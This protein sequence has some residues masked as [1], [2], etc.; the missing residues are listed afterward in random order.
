MREPACAPRLPGLCRSSAGVGVLDRSAKPELRPG[1]GSARTPLPGKTRLRSEQTAD[2]KTSKPERSSYKS[3][4]ES[5][6][7]SRAGQLTKNPSRC[8]HPRHRC[9]GRCRNHCRYRLIVVAAI[10]V[11]IA[12]LAL[13][14]ATIV[15]LVLRGRVVLAVVSPTRAGGDAQGEGR[16]Q[17]H[18]PQQRLVRNSLPIFLDHPDLPNGLILIQR[19]HSRGEI[20]PQP[21]PFHSLS[22]P[23]Q[24]LQPR[25]RWR[26]H[27][28]R[29]QAPR[30]PRD[31]GYPGLAQS[32]GDGADPEGGRAQ[33]DQGS[34]DQQEDRTAGVRQN[35]YT[36]ARSRDDLIVVRAVGVV[37]VPAC[38]G[39]SRR[40]SRAGD[41]A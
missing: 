23:L 37:I 11:V 14:T 13:T 12:I 18:Y 35:A 20:E 1:P 33:G 24:R 28:E 4:C 40:F 26:I 6:H 7:G 25:T 29:V 16:Y 19:T 38:A 17:V 10:V 39:S 9:R 15:A 32:P 41:T 2:Q 30:S 34:S 27:G 21:S 3:G 8:H 31:P 36:A 5:S 22:T